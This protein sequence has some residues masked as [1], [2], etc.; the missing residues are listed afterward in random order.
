VN[1]NVL[2]LTGDGIG[3]ILLA[4]DE[5]SDSGTGKHSSLYTRSKSSTPTAAWSPWF[6]VLDSGN[7]TKYI[8]TSTGEGA[9]GTWNINIL[10][11][12]SAA[13][14]LLP[15][16]ANGTYERATYT[17]PSGSSNVI[18]WSEAFGDNTLQYA[19]NGELH[20]Y[21]DTGDIVF[22][23]SPNPTDDELLLNMYINGTYEG[24][25]KGDLNG[26]AT[27]AVNAALTTITNTLTYFD[28]T[29]GHFNYT[30]Y[31]K[32]LKHLSVSEE[33]GQVNAAGYSDGLIIHS[34]GTYYSL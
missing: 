15:I 4:W 12:A 23:L 8:A 6:E 17:L 20:N 33:S 27:K 9:S 16:T 18:I 28:N 10:G 25:F 7:F 2:T 34:T 30:P 21:T 14:F 32:Y 24:Y 3:Q 13:S 11:N 31:I 5:T 19:A 1:G 22:Y 29:L 26:T